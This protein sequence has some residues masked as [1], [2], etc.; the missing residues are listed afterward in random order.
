MI[1]KKFSV[2]EY[3]IEKHEKRGDQIIVFCDAI[4]TNK[5]FAKNCG[6]GKASLSGSS[7]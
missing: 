3:L 1:E 7:D 2:L 4:R 6:S 5:L